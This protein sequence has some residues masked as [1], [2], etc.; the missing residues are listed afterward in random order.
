M[1]EVRS[2]ASERRLLVY[3][4]LFAVTSAVLWYVYVSHDVAASTAGLSCLFAVLA[5]CPGVLW[6]A[7]IEV[8]G[9]K[10]DVML[11][12]CLLLVGWAVYQFMVPGRDF[13][14]AL[15]VVCLATAIAIAAG[16]A[17]ILAVRARPRQE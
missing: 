8:S 2:Q 6:L 17:M 15:L 13:D 16:I 5:I 12:W 1:D 7:R 10:L 11:A 9:F 3:S 4:A 14:P